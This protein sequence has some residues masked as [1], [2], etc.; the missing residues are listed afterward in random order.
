[1]P[2]AFYDYIESSL[3]LVVASKARSSE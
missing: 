1:L 2:G 3:A